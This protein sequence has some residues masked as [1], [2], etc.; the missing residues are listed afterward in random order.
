M[1]YLSHHG[2]LGQKWGVRRYQNS[3]GSY[4]ATGKNR[5]AERVEKKKQ[6]ILDNGKAAEERRK[7]GTSKLGDGRKIHLA[8]VEQKR[9]QRIDEGEVVKERHKQ[10]DYRPGDGRKIHQA[11]VEKRRVQYQIYKEKRKDQKKVE[12]ALLGLGVAAVVGK[13]YVNQMREQAYI[14][15]IAATQYGSQKGLN[16]VQGGFVTGF[17]HA[18]AGK[19]FVEALNS[20]SV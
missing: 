1:S 11:N 6:K 14:T 15:S 5:Y 2:I 8:K 13:A 7:S 9:Q 19:K 4:T 20:R 17:K 18:Q 12:A 16:E 3:D 10:G